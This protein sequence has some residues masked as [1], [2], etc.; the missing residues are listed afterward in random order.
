VHNH[1]LDGKTG[2]VL[3]LADQRIALI[4][5]GGGEVRQHRRKLSAAGRFAGIGRPA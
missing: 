5:Q 4:A 2:H 1:D 3:Q